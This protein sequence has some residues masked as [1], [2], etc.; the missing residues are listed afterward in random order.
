[1]LQ[2]YLKIALRNLWKHKLFSF[3]NVFG[4]AS[5]LTV[6]L[7]AIA[8]IKGTFDYDN[9][10][11]NRDRTYRII[12]DVIGKDN[13]LAS[14]ATSPMPL[15]ALLKQQYG[16]IEEAARAVKEYGEFTG[17]HKRL[18]MMSFAVDPAFFRIFNFKLA[19]GRPATEPN[20]VV[21]TQETAERFFGTANPVG[22]T[23][24]N[25]DL[26]TFTV[27][28]VLAEPPAKSHLRFD[29]LYSLQT[30]HKPEHRAAFEQWNQFET[31]HTYVLVKP[32]TPDDAL[33][34]ILPS[35]VSRVTRGLSF[36]T[37]KSYSFRTQRLDRL[38]PAR[39]E[40]MW[41]TYEPQIT[42][43]LAEFG[44]GLVTLLLAAFNYINLTLARSLSRAREVG[45]RKVAGAL[46]RQVMGQFMAESIV[47]SL[48]ALGLAFVMLEA[49]K[50][51]AFVQ[52]WLIGGVHWD[53]TLWSTFIGF[54][55]IAGLL[56]GIVP[57][58]VLSGFEPAQVLRSQ[59]GLKIARG[60]S[61]R[62]TL[63]VIQFAISLVAMIALRTMIRQ[64]DYMATG[65]Y[66]FRQERLL[67]LPINDVPVQRFT[68]ELNRLSG[69]EGVSPISVMLADHG[70][71]EIA[72]VRRQRSALDSAMAFVMSVD[73][74]FL[75][76]M[77]LSL[78]AGRNLSRSVADSSGH[79]VLVNEEA[80]RTFGLNDSRAAI[81]QTIWL[82][83]KEVQIAGVVRDFR[84]TT[85]NWDIKPL[86]LRY[87]PANFR[88]I[89]VAVAQGAEEAVL[90]DVRR[91][92]KQFLPYEPFAGQWYTDYLR[93]RHSHTEDTDFM[94]L[95]L[96]LAFSIACLGL[97]GM[98]TYNTQTRVKE[99]GV[100]KVLGAEVRQIVWLLS[101]DFVRLL[102]LA[103]AIAMPL[104]YL[105]GYA[106]LTSF[107]YHVS[108]G[109]ETFGLCV[110]VL[111]VLGVLT[112]GIRTY[113]AALANPADS[114]R[115]E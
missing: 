96:A 19:K 58:R 80:L 51:M 110:G 39:E 88:Y 42:G 18:T 11:P 14:F 100:R 102:L 113:R 3:I 65:D 71:E 26:G 72:M 10:H 47:L 57:A 89:N 94:G 16:F 104:G 99:V 59:T 6:C 54:S 45:I 38:S 55:I 90:A 101:R 98:V 112:I 33:D 27:T 93:Q 92:W 73:A 28:G 9:F 108:I 91:I 95:L 50:P 84:Y 46:R 105:A 48:L 41:G 77:Q 5:G 12:T 86:I 21:L 25:S 23:L 111:L 115:T 4:L 56:A 31:G 69:V 70:G 1:M 32:D 61:L 13:D 109:L 44:V 81:G 60:F 37:A 22:Q 53:W 43:L 97:L 76:T 63:I 79:F 40:L 17:N 64:M 114:L 75:P 20:T 85:F 82:R 36:K 30:L 8:H 106:F 103:A 34:K 52:Q 87:E 62:K 74:E 66:G 7:L 78:L 49:V 24:Q 35:V 67:T 2:N 68:N 15:G 83:D 29:M 107:A